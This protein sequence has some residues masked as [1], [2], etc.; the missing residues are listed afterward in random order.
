MKE[1]LVGL[2]IDENRIK[3]V[4]YGEELVIAKDDENGLSEIKGRVEFN[5]LG[6]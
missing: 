3:A 6:E 4:G 5:I 1:F 2:G